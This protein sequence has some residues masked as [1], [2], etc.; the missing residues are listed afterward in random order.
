MTN[1]ISDGDLFDAL[2]AAD[3]LACEPV[4]PVFRTEAALAQLLASGLDAPTRARS[5]HRTRR[6]WLVRVAPLMMGVAGAVAIVTVAEN[7]GS[8]HAPQQLSAARAHMVLARA[9]D[10]LTGAHGAILEADVSSTQT[11]SDGRSATVNERDWQELAKPFDERSITTGPWPTPVETATVDGAQWL[12]DPSTNTIYTADPT[13][14]FTLSAGPR[15]ATFTLHVGHRT[16]VVSAAQAAKL[17]SGADEWAV[18]S[19]PSEKLIVIPRPEVGSQ[20]LSSVRHLAIKLLRA[21]GSTV[22]DGGTVDGQSVIQITSADGKT[23]YDVAPVTYTP[24][25]IRQSDPD[26]PG[27]SPSTTTSSF[28]NWQK[29]K[30]TPADLALLSLTAQ[31]PSATVNSSDAGYVA[32]ENHLFP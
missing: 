24:I 17:H 11:S 26:L 22:T 27:N 13:P 28:T 7:G 29:L 9:A 2:R 3:P 19:G 18:A 21:P 8:A 5:R 4:R 16:R 23:V 32:A 30:G 25:Q 12:Y 15:P 20:T 14:P 31:H 6:R 1:S 10:V